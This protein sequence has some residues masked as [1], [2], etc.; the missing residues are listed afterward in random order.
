MNKK[1]FGAQRRAARFKEFKS[2]RPLP[3]REV[4]GA[5]PG[6]AAR[7]DFRT[8]KRGWGMKRM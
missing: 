2:Y 5:G 7:A 8:Q 6:T 4:A 3:Y 1:Y